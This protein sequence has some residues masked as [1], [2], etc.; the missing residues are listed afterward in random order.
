MDVVADLGA[1]VGGMVS[2]A[3]CRLWQLAVRCM[4]DL[5]RDCAGGTSTCAGVG[6]SVIGMTRRVLATPNLAQC[7]SCVGR[8]HAAAVCISRLAGRQASNNLGSIC[9]LASYVLVA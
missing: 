1:S 4:A 5:C 3:V 2:A 6:A 9:G 7:S 8:W